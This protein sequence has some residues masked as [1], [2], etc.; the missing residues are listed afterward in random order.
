MPVLHQR[1]ATL[2]CLCHLLAKQLSVIA[3]WRDQI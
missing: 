1:Y 3:I 2:Q